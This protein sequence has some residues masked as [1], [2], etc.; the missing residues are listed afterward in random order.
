MRFVKSI[1]AVDSHT[2]GEPTRVVVGGIPNV[3]G[4]TMMEKKHYLE[5]HYDSIRTALMLEP[6]GH[7]DMFGSIILPPCDPEADLG[8]VFMEGD[9][10]VNMCGHG[11][12]GACSVA[13]ETGLVEA[14]EPFTDITLECPVGLIKARVA[15]DHCKAKSV[16]IT[17][18]PSFL[19]YGDVE[20]DI[21]G[22]GVVKF[23]IAYGGNFALL[24]DAKYFGVDI[25][26]EN[27]PVLIEKANILN[28]WVNANMTVQHPTEPDVHGVAMIEVYG[29][30]KSAG[31]DYQD[32]VIFGHSIDRS[33]C[34]V[35]TCAKMATLVA[36]GELS[37]GDNFVY[38]SIIQTKFSGKPLEKTRVGDYDAIIPEVSASAFITGFNHFVFDEDDPVLYGFRV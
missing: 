20:K 6:R 7:R 35:G 15:V 21:P 4:N 9:G 22:L 30:P 29:P 11:S 18:V 3:P 37:I 26:P 33:P 8:I 28:N 24:I 10:F 23:D 5:E 34:G 16:T 1:Y 14:K 25:A 17:N 31:A 36:K 38:E 13:V 12:I 32:C 19:L 2:M 27:L